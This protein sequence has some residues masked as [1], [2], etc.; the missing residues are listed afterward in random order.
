MLLTGSFQEYPL[1][2]LLEIFLHRRETGLLEISSPKQTGYFYIRNGE[3]KDG[4]IGPVK[5][6]AA[7]ELA[8]SFADAAFQFK[9]LEP[10]DYAQIVWEKNF[11]SKR[12]VADAPATPATVSQTTFKQLRLYTEAAFATFERA[13][14]SLAN[15]GLRLSLSSLSVAYHGLHKS[16][17][18]VTRRISSYCTLVYDFSKRVQ[19][20]RR[21]STLLLKLLAGLQ[22]ALRWSAAAIREGAVSLQRTLTL[23]RKRAVLPSRRQV[24]ESNISFALILL[25]IVVVG[26]VTI[27]KILRMDQEDFN[28]AGPADEDARSQSQPSK[29]VSRPRPKQNPRNGKQ[30]PLIKK[31]GVG[32]ASKEIGLPVASVVRVSESSNSDVPEIEPASTSELKTIAV[33]VHVENGRASRVALLEPRQ[34][35]M[36]CY[37]DAALRIARQRRYPKAGQHTEIVEV[38]VGQPQQ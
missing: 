7:I 18:F 6:A 35:G 17:V 9:P 1:N 20:G 5:G 24:A 33:V 31:R 14:V 15:R 38:R 13:G 28:L 21:L 37:E 2:L 34:P 23:I 27:S 25:T 4:A 19:F 26:V 11:G 3:I 32:L 29:Q 22:I 30:T 8:G 10:T 12:V 36:D 16:A